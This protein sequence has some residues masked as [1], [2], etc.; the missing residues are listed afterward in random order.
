MAWGIR[1]VLQTSAPGVDDA[2]PVLLILVGLP[3]LERGRL[4]HSF[5]L[6][7]HVFS[8]STRYINFAVE[9]K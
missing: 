4:L 8:L 7:V 6:L 1:V 3:C 5:L 2:E 9:L